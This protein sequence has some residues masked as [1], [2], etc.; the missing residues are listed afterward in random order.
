MVLELVDTTRGRMEKTI[1]DLTL[2]LSSIRTGRAS[3]HFL[4]KVVVDYY[5]TQT[6]IN[7]LAT[8]HVPEPSLITIQPWDI[9]QIGE[10]EKAI[11]ASN[12]GLTPSSDGRLIRLQIPPLTQERRQELARHVGAIAED[13]RT[14]LR[15]IRRDVNE[16]LKRALKD[17]KISEDE[18]HKAL[19][20]VQNI[21]DEYVA[22][23]G[24]LADQKQ[25]EI[26][27]V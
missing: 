3:V 25:E 8:L 23:V 1:K 20:E 9:S 22:N 4:D 18:E 21:T 16:K 19:K 15:N 26:L 27:E 10:I 7:Q 5:G 13:H 14:A 11:M 17:K 12:L 24:E 6:P 2:N